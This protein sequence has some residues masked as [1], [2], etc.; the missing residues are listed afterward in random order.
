MTYLKFCQA[1]ELAVVWVSEDDKVLLPLPHALEPVH[2]PHPAVRDPLED[3]QACKFISCQ[4]HL[5]FLLSFLFYGGAETEVWRAAVQKGKLACVTGQTQW[6]GGRRI[7]ETALYQSMYK[8]VYHPVTRYSSKCSIQRDT[9]NSDT[10][11]NYLC[12]EMQIYTLTLVHEQLNLKKTSVKRVTNKVK[13][14][15]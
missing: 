8:Y 5:G 15:W 14:L 6:E 1:C 2:L 4:G 10:W 11:K 12:K 9:Y 3:E 13:H 7:T